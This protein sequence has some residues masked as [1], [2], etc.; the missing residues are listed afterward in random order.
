MKNIYRL[1]LLCP[2]A[3]S[4]FGC[5]SKNTGTPVDVVIISGQSNG[6]GCTYSNELPNSMGI[7]K[8]D[9]YVNGYS[10]I[11]IAY[12]NWTKTFP[13][14]N[15]ELQNAPMKKGFVDVKLGQGNGSHSFGP[16]IGIAEVTHEKY[17]NKLF[18]IKFAC[19]GSNL[20][21]DW[22]KRKSPMYPKLID[23][24]KK[25]MEYLKENGYNP[26][27]KAFCWMQGEGDSYPGYHDVYYDN[28]K[29]FVGNVRTDLKELSGN[30]D[31]AFIDAGINDKGRWEYWED[32]NN[33][34]IKFAS[35]SENNIY[36]DT[37]AAGMHTDKEPTSQVDIDHYDSDSQ[38]LLGHLFAEAFEPFLAK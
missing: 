5:T 26:T 33:A 20:K 14:L 29:T 3:I 17:A 32:V 31:M 27:I 1:F 22:L 25:Q 23:Y 15:F 10:D 2:M 21:D 38:I 19:G 36:I 37:I 18:L 11:K 30:K 13:D 4:L 12:N 6:V 16:E 9:E 7:E 35:E 24:V 28:L 34:K 8:Y